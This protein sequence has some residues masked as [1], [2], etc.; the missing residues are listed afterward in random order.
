MSELIE[1]NALWVDELGDNVED[2]IMDEEFVVDEADVGIDDAQFV[3]EEPKEQFEQQ[4]RCH[5]HDRL[6]K[7]L[8]QHSSF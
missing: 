5:R 7:K 6:W 3:V 1:K 8:F 4:C 2:F